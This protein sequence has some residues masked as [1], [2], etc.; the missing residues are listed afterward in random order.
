[1]LLAAML[2][3]GC[4]TG[5]GGSFCRVAAPILLEPADLEVISDRLAEDILAHNLKGRS[6]CRW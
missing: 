3:S 1:M 2:A 4:A 6:L 5:S